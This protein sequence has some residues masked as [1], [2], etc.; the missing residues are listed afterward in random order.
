MRFSSRS[1]RLGS[2]AAIALLLL[3]GAAQAQIL[4][5]IQGVVSGENGEALPG[6]TVTVTNQETGAERI[7]VTGP[8]GRYSVRSLPSGI[9]TVRTALDG[10]QTTQQ[11]NV[12]LFVGQV[13]D[14]NVEMSVEAQE[15]VITVTADSPLIEV[16]RAETASYI[17]EEE[18]ELIPITGQ[19]F[20]QYAILNPT[21][22]DDPQRGFLN[23]S[24]QR[25]IYSGLRVDGVSNKNAFFGYANGGEATEN[26]GVTI[27]SAAVKEFQVVQ[28]GFAPEYGL[29]GGGYVNLITKSGTNEFHGTLGYLYTDEGL[30][31][32]FEPTPL[33]LSRDPTAA[34]TPQ[35]EF[36]RENFQLTFGGPIQRDKAHF[37]VSYDDTER[38]SPFIEQLRTRGA[39]DAV[40]LRGQ[41]EPE[42]LSLLDGYTPNNDGIAAPDPIN[43]RTAEGLFSR[44][45]DNKIFLGKVD[46]Y[47]S[48][49]H[50]ASL[51]YNL[52]DYSRTSTWADEESLKEEEV[53]SII[54][55]WVAVIGN[56][57]LND[58][59][60]QYTTDDLNRGNLRVGSDLEALIRFRGGDGSSTDQLGKFDFLPIVANTTQYEFRDS[61]S[62]L[63]DDHDLKFG[64]EYSS[65]T[66]EQI[67]AGSKDG[68]Y[69]FATLQDFLNN[70]DDQVRIYFGNVTFPN[71]DEKQ[72]VLAI[73]A[74]DQWKPNAKLTVDFGFRYGETKNPDNLEHVF[75]FARDIPDDDHI[76][77][78]IGFAYQ[79]SDDGTDVLRGGYGHFYGRTPTLLFAS[80]VQENGIFP[81][82]G[83][84]T[85]SPGDTG[86]VP[87]G[88]PINNQNPP[89]DTIPSTSYLETSFRDARN[90]RISLG[91]ERQLA[92]NWSA[93]FDYL[94]ASGDYLQRNYDD[95]NV[96]AGNDAFG[97][98]RFTG[99]VA[100]PNFDTIFVR[101]SNG[102]SSYNAYTLRVVRRFST[103]Y[104]FQAHYTYSS[105]KDDDSNE[106]NA[107][108]I[109]ISNP[110]DPGYDWGVSARNIEHRFV[111]LGSVD[112][113]ANFRLSGTF[114][115]QSGLPWTA[116]DAN[117]NYANCHSFGS[118]P[119]ARAVING[120]LVGRNSFTNESTNRLDLRLAWFYDF[121]RGEVELFA[122]MFNVFDEQFFTVNET[123]DR[124]QGAF[125]TT[126][127][128]TPQLSNGDPNPEFGIPDVRTGF[129]RAWQWGIRLRM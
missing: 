31:D 40:M 56:N 126:S 68:R 104:Q 121:S 10:M 64:V 27:S 81:N 112:L 11:E 69:D 66:M 20:K 83:R 19:D 50:Q 4:G 114:R 33:D 21:V 5:S 82:Y 110:L 127:S 14:I 43:G 67:F 96:F 101:S 35:D 1:L 32:D 8:S 90:E 39:F 22:V 80:Q 107:T 111:A 60:F 36:E 62:Y 25:G 55:S 42:F 63:F 97:R 6:V 13:I 73:F 120:Q 128:Q 52:T 123:F 47:P 30:T 99:D 116:R 102:N 48:D 54:G 75:P 2:V 106:R 18:I 23:M 45:V 15:E 70:N 95:N 16:S 92:R 113:P 94:H 85:V 3:V 37:F 24:G 44:T 125:D 129:P 26:D 38:T 91:Y 87:L 115:A 12:Q 86:H 77:P 29:D 65:D 71:Y 118:C 41:T 79:L 88:T 28:N 108:N 46:F 57:G 93:S 51:R 78:R 109:T 89:V 17:S 49:S 72:E 105:D 117:I 61:F 58:F 103:N 53:D 100:N 119:A 9:Y 7:T 76:S 84:V 74:Q 124:A 122:E 98:P 34:D 59:R